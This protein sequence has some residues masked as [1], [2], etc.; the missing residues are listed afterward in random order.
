M[1]NKDT[2]KLLGFQGINKKYSLKE[3]KEFVEGKYKGINVYLETSK[4][5]TTCPKCSEITNKKKDS[6]TRILKHGIQNGKTMFI[7]LKYIRYKCNHCHSSFYEE[8]TDICTKYQRNTNTSIWNVIDNY[9]T[10]KFS[11]KDISK[12]SGLNRKQIDKLYAI[13]V[14]LMGLSDLTELPEHIGIDE[15]KGNMRHTVNGKSIKYKYQIQITNLETGKVIALLPVKDND[16]ISEFL[17]KITNKTKVKT[18]AIDMSMQFK[19]TFK[20]AFKEAEI[21]VDYF[22]LTKLVTATVDKMRI[23]LWRKY[24]GSKTKESKEI[25][26]YL[27]SLKSYLLTDYNACK[28]EYYKQKIKERL[29]KVFEHCEE[30]KLVYNNLQKFYDIKRLESGAEKIVSFKLWFKDICEEKSI[31]EYKS[32]KKTIYHWYTYILNSYKTKYSNGK[33]EGNNNSIKVL[34]R[35]SYGFRNYETARNRILACC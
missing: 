5:E 10:Y 14:G 26:K 19:R 18:V 23:E 29:D 3:V 31:E 34:K 28:N 20:L 9:L 35:V 22:H 4:I 16:C 27:K 13:K 2:I 6:R 33:T 12:L 32:L 30:L 25:R 17:S 11:T 15:F 7:H 1:H 8:I 24:T 21:V